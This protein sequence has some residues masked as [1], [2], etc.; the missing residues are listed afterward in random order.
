VFE[1]NQ[2]PLLIARALELKAVLSHREA[3]FSP[4]FGPMGYAT[5]SDAVRHLEE[6][7]HHVRLA[8]IMFEHIC[9]TAH[10]KHLIRNADH[11]KQFEALMKELK[12]E[13]NNEV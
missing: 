6:A 11:L 2:D 10:E 8:L 4:L 5:P 1:G 7:I 3:L 12:E 13:E 9:K